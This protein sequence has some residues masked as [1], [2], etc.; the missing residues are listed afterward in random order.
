MSLVNRISWYRNRGSVPTSRQ[1]AGGDT[2]PCVQ[3]WVLFVGIMAGA[4]GC[5]PTHSS[6][7]LFP[8]KIPIPQ[9]R[10]EVLQVQLQSWPSVVRAQG[11]LVADEISTVGAKSAG[12][13]DAVHVDLGDKVEQQ[14]PLVTLDQKDLTLVV[15]QVEAQLSQARAAV[16]LMPG[17][18]AEIL[19]PPNAPPSREA[20]AV[21]DEA[22]AN[23]NRLR[24]LR[25]QQAVSDAQ[26]DQALSSE[27]V[28]EA[29]YASALNGV[30][31][32][33][34]EIAVKT[35]ELALAQQKLRDGITLAPFSGEVQARFVAPGTFV[36]IGQPLVALV[37]TGTLRFRGSL[38][39]RYAQRIA[40]GQSV[41]LRFES[42][43][44][45]LTVK[46]TRVSPALDEVTRSLTFEASLDNRDGALRPGLFAEA[47][48][49]LDPNA[50][51]V[52]VP[53]S[54]VV[55]FAGAEKVWKVIGGQAQEQ[56]VRIGRRTDEGYEI[57]EGLAAGDIILVQGKEGRV[58][59]VEA[60]SPSLTQ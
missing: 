34:A 21:W 50:S 11:S 32:K 20:K 18:S 42:S 15:Q 39:E 30:R 56:P 46:V 29:R 7:G 51:A 27:R 59:R 49:V 55:E 24:Q 57:R 48:L 43:N 33:L 1:L 58:A 26:F 5:G 40:V 16:G 44:Q 14:T 12:R 37:R 3:L 35:A 13:V 9:L 41:T 52:V 38:P 31:E 23:T 47:E 22:I 36:Q 45:P 28:A 6:G 8:P 54:A 60:A 25:Q 10:A 2:F 19:D 53:A 4:L 17:Q